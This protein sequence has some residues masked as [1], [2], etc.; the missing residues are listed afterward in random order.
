M[1]SPAPT[2]PPPAIRATRGGPGRFGA[3][4]ARVRTCTGQPGP[5]DQDSPERQSAATSSAQARVTA[6]ICGQDGPPAATG[7]R[8][9]WLPP[10]DG[11]HQ[12]AA[13]GRDVGRAAERVRGA[14][15]HQRRQAGGGRQVELGQAGLLRCG[16]AGAAGRRAR[17]PRW[18]RRR[19]RCGTRPGRRP[20]GRR[21]AAGRSLRGARA[22]RA[23][24]GRASVAASPPGGRRRST[25]ARRGPPRCPAA[26]SPSASATRSAAPMP[27]PAP[28]P[29]TRVARRRPTA[30]RTSTRASPTGVATVRTSEE[31]GLVFT[32]CPRRPRPAR[33]PRPAAA[34]P[35]PGRCSSRCS[36]SWRRGTPSA[37]QGLRAP[38]GRAAGRSPRRAGSSHSAYRSRSTSSGIRSWMRPSSSVAVVVSTVTVHSHGS[39]SASSG[40]EGSRHSSYS[41]AIASTPPSAGR[42]KNG[43][44]LPFTSPYHSK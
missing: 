23:R 3:G 10:S 35:A 18:P 12:P 40:T 32:R 2:L 11:D 13:R 7:T 44:F 9:E 5:R 19:S 15:Q 29:S 25:A 6:T 17:A 21:R 43:C 27:P 37:G 38:G 16:P 33:H 39:M 30:A 26:G 41:P 36:R 22:R 24:R 34:R 14:L 20:T 1:L 42:M 28:W 4:S 31:L 8:R